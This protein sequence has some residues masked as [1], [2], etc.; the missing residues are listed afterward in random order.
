MQLFAFVYRG[1]ALI[2]AIGL[3]SACADTKP[4]SFA[5]KVRQA[6]E[7]AAFTGPAL[8]R[9]ADE[10][11]TVYLFGTVHTLRPE[12]RWEVPIILDALEAADAIYFEAD[13]VS[14]AAQNEISEV[15]TERGL[16]TDGRILQ[17]VLPEDAEREVEEATDLLG[18]PSQSI[19]NFKPW[20]ASMQLSSVHLQNRNFDSSLGVERVIGAEAN[21]RGTPIRYLETGAYQLGLLASVPEAEQV[22]MLVQTAK[23]IEDDPDFLETLIS[24]W[25]EGDV[26]TLAD[27]IA[28]DIVFE[29]ILAAN[30]IVAQRENPTKTR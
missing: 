22:A 7:E 16:F 8:W 2:L 19:H 11:T 6:A 25:A 5:D 9:V 10:D 27:L 23:Q 18:I 1:L 20:F 21:A 26:P 12:T 15:L 24:E 4:E 30:G 3:L 29:N 13:T 28:N 14:P 17:D